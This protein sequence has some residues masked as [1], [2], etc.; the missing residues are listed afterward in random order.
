MNEKLIVWSRR[1][2]YLVISIVV[3]ACGG[4]EESDQ[5]NISTK[6]G[7]S[8]A[9]S[10][11]VRS[12]IT[13]PS[14]S[15]NLDVQVETS[16][17]Y[18]TGDIVIL[19]Q[20]AGTTE[21]FPLVGKVVQTVGSGGGKVTATLAPVTIPEVFGKVKLDI[22]TARDFKVVRTATAF[23]PNLSRPLATKASGA[24]RPQTSQVTRSYVRVIESSESSSGLGVNITR[25]IE[26]GLS[27]GGKLG[28]NLAVENLR[29]AKVIDYSGCTG[30][31]CTLNDVG[32]YKE[33]GDNISGKWRLSLTYDQSR[34]LGE[35]KLSDLFDKNQ[36]WDEL[37]RNLGAYTLSGLDGSD[38]EGLYPI[39]GLVLAST[40]IP[41]MTVLSNPNQ[42]W[43]AQLPGA[44]TIFIIY[45]KFDGSLKLKGTS[46]IL[47]TAG[48]IYQQVSLKPGSGASELLGSLSGGFQSPKSVTTSVSGSLDAKV[49]AGV[50]ASVDLI[51][52]GIRPL[53][54]TFEAGGE[55]TESVIANTEFRWAPEFN[56]GGYYCLKGNRRIYGALSVAGALGMSVTSIDG[57]RTRNFGTEFL[58][59]RDHTFYQW[60]NSG[61]RCISVDKPRFSATEL[62]D[63]TGVNNGLKLV[64][65][66]I[67]STAPSLFDLTDRWIFSVVS[68]GGYSLPVEA[69]IGTS[70]KFTAYLPPSTQHQIALS[71]YNDVYG[72][73]TESSSVSLGTTH[74]ATQSAIG[75]LRGPLAITWAEGNN[76]FS[77][78]YGLTNPLLADLGTSHS[79]LV[80]VSH[81]SGSP[82]AGV[83]PSG[84][85]RVS[86][87]G[88]SCTGSLVT[89]PTKAG[90]TQNSSVAGY[91][92]PFAVPTTTS[93]QA[94]VDFQYSGDARYPALNWTTTIDMRVWGGRAFASSTE[95]LPG[96]ARQQQITPNPSAPFA[97][98]PSAKVRIRSGNCADLDRIIDTVT[99]SSA[100]TGV[101]TWTPASGVI[102]P[103]SYIELVSDAASYYAGPQRTNRD[104]GPGERGCRP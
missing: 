50:A 75:A 61:S 62:S 98:E 51:L 89:I 88:V 23:S 21:I 102:N 26:I 85:V 72:L 101:V 82:A 8:I 63:G 13:S 33:V 32:T 103:A 78:G 80:L 76:G 36:M 20:P 104:S 99:L 43:L 68:P 17:G 34:S 47:Q 94:L 29:S 64:E 86:Y 60:P 11:S 27:N 16:K 91:Y 96:G 66:D 42:L 24:E 38:K 4:N 74:I 7:V 28:L 69:V 30:A 2:F 3:A 55:I 93:R 15:G 31:G 40:T 18:R 54:I 65:F 10:G 41:P 35:I 100:N 79:M 1:T 59:K 49:T 87:L 57:E 77:N 46:T 56:V 92:C 70:K 12:V 58:W 97:L 81:A 6:E 83:P 9:D 67:S 71:A 25:G 95:A 37:K 48:D 73:I 52:S 14:G 44:H 39:A 5:P 53:S 45:V 84:T 19:P 90:A 22:D